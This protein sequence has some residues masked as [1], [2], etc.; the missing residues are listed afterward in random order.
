MQFTAHTQPLRTLTR[1]QPPRTPRHHPPHHRTRTTRRPTTTTRQRTQP[2]PRPGWTRSPPPVLQPRPPTNQRGGHLPHT[3]IR[4]P[5]PPGRQ[6]PRRLSQRLRRPRRHHH[7]TPGNSIRPGESGSSGTWSQSSTSRGLFQDHVRVGPADPERRHRRPPR[8]AHLRPRPR[9]GQQLAPHPPTSPH[10]ATAHPHATSRGNTPC[11]IAI[12]ILITPAT[13]AAACVCP[14][15]D[16]TDPSHNG[17]SRTPLPIRRQQRLRLDRITQRRPRPMRLHHIHISRRQ[18]RIR[19]RLP[20]HP[21]LRRTIRRRQ[22]IRRTILIHRRTP[23]HRQHPMPIPPRIRQPLHHQHPDTLAPA[24][25][26]RRRRERLAPPVRRQPALPAELDEDARASPSPSRRRP[27]PA[28]TRPT[29]APA[30]PDAAPPTTTN[31]PCPPSPP[32]PPDPN[33]YATRPDTTLPALPV[34]SS[35]R[36]RR[37][38]LPSARSRGT[39]RPAN[40]PVRL[41]RSD[42]RVDPGP[43]ER[44]PRR[45][46]QQPLLRIHRQRL[47]RRDPE[48]PRRR[49]RSASCRKPPSPRVA[50]CPAMPG[51]GSY[52]PSRSQPRSVGNADDRVRP[53]GDQLPQVLGRCRRR[54]GTGRPCPRSRSVPSLRRAARRCLAQPLVLDQGVTQ[55]LDQLVNLVVHGSSCSARC[56]RLSPANAGTR[57][58]PS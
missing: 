49:T 1:K 56:A 42:G 11:R 43:L 23:H 2:S 33:V 39:S 26:V 44:L 28:S 46:Q 29:A 17:R 40:T 27:A 53:V 35:P 31:T 18:P 12:T 14:I 55:R 57:R 20:D 5:S 32:G 41:P 4:T 34:P 47:T 10:A 6:P 38:V 37:D 15:F 8:P 50:S 21:L 30:P 25:T 48:E 45:L 7:R 9:L 51:S 19:Q 52:R 22:P 36:A 24:R 13:P 54:P 58:A 16:F 3:H